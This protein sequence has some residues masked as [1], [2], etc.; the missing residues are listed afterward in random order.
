M[1]L[2]PVQQAWRRIQARERS[3]L[4]VAAVLMIAAAFN[5]VLL[6]P[7]RQ[8]I[9]ASR[10]ELAASRSQLEKL[11]HIVE[12]RDRVRVEDVRRRQADLEARRAAA[13]AAIRRAQIELITPQDMQR[14]LAAILRRFPEL[15]VVGMLTEAPTPLDD[16]A[17]GDGKALESAQSRRLVLFRH[18]LELTVEGGYP[19]LI[20][21]LEELEHAPYRIYWRELELKVDGK[22]APL[23]KIRFFTL[24]RG[25]EWLTL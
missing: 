7:L 23:T 11:Q 1:K 25:P 18:G 22:G 14:Q 17:T 5:S 4:I 8:K 15:K 19:D 13:D 24:S 12:E 3:L 20:N 2:A 16:N 6:G 10:S 21:Y 9:A